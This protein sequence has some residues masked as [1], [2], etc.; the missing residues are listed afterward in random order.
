MKNLLLILPLCL[1]PACK[2]MGAQDVALGVLTGERVYDVALEYRECMEREG[3]NKV[4]GAALRTLIDELLF[5]IAT[6]DGGDGSVGDLALDAVQRL[7][8]GHDACID[9]DLAKSEA[10]KADAKHRS[11]QLLA[12]VRRMVERVSALD[13]APPGV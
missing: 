4:D 12:L 8:A 11:A 3:L 5:Y 1:L 7:V 13:S 2:G 6:M 9:A 10:Q